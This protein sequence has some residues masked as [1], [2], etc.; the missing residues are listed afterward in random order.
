[1]N[2]KRIA[3]LA[4]ACLAAFSFNV[5][6]Q[7]YPAKPVKIIIPYPPGGGIDFI[8]RVAGEK[9]SA[10]WGQPVVVENRTGASGAIGSEA[11]AKSEADG[12]T[13]LVMPIDLML[14]PSLVQNPR[15]DPLKD[16]APIAVLATSTQ[17]IAA[18]GASGIRTLADLVARAK[19]E[20]GRAHKAR[21]RG[22][23]AP[24]IFRCGSPAV[25]LEAWTEAENMMVR[26]STHTAS[27]A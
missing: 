23:S 26:A 4:F 24:T 12:Y 6:A 7:S 22:T 9:L 15:F 13:L 19:A 10:R 1:M 3:G 11:A 17:I 21:P 25:R 8:G 14:N 20:P 18:H 5:A 2:F 27:P 16:L